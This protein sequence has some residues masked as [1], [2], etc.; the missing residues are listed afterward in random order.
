MNHN[1]INFAMEI[2]IGAGERAEGDQI[3]TI[4]HRALS[5]SHSMMAWQNLI[6]T[7][8]DYLRIYQTTIISLLSKI[9]EIKT[10]RI[11]FIAQS[12]TSKAMN[13]FFML[14]DKLLWFI[15]K[16]AV[17]HPKH[18]FRNSLFLGRL[19]HIATITF[20]PTRKGRRHLTLSRVSFILPLI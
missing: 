7:A 14:E 8:I 12:F 19:F 1:R 20:F 5:P 17:C 3:A 2:M 10:L 11:L 9:Y 13:S 16:E 6:Y 18:C 15:R 4:K